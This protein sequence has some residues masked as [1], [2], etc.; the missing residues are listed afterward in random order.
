MFVSYPYLAWC[1]WA[2]NKKVQLWFHVVA[3]SLLRKLKELLLYFH[4][5]FKNKCIHLFQSQEKTRWWNDPANLKSE[6]H[7]YILTPNIQQYSIQI[8]YLVF[9]T[10]SFFNFQLYHLTPVPYYFI[11]KLL[12]INHINLLSLPLVF[13]R[14]SLFHLLWKAYNPWTLL[15]SY[16]SFLIPSSSFQDL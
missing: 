5:P 9:I 4:I 13:L 14:L 7:C 12:L 16:H 8:L 3:C 10:Y 2:S 1:M 6:Y 15:L 11:T